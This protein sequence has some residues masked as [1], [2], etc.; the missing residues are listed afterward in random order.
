MRQLPPQRMFPYA[1]S[2]SEGRS[3][4]RRCWGRTYRIS[5]SATVRPHTLLTRQTKHVKCGAF[6]NATVNCTWANMITSRCRGI[7]VFTRTHSPAGGFSHSCKLHFWV[8]SGCVSS[9]QCVC[10][11][12]CSIPASVL[13]HLMSRCCSPPPQEAEH[14]EVSKKQKQQKE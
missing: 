12:S 10:S 9:S 2:L 7:L 11:I 5:E 6:K 14:C 8:F 13:M 4:K 3:K 1:A